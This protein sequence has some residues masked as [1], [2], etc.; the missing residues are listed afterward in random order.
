MRGAGWQQVFALPRRPVAN[1]ALTEVPPLPGVY[2][3]FRDG[4]AIYVGEAKGAKGLR[5]RLGAHL[6]EGLDLSRSTLR[7][8]V[9]VQVLEVARSTARE[10][11]SVLTAE[12][13]EHVNRWLRE[14]ELAWVVCE[15]AAAAHHME[16]MLRTEWLPPLNRT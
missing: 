3:W 4:E 14:C 16:S 12:Q 8:S 13:V 11:P 15:D 1:L 9:A 7:A 5:G 10:R 6:R 2:I